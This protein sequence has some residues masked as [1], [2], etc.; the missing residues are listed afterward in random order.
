M[1]SEFA[2]AL[3]RAVRIQLSEPNLPVASTTNDLTIVRKRNEFRL[4]GKEQV[5]LEGEADGGV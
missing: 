2:R 1:L 4:D 5:D 3:E